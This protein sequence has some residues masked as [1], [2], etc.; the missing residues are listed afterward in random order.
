MIFLLIGIAIIALALAFYLGFRYHSW[1]SSSPKQ[2]EKNELPSAPTIEK[3]LEPTQ[4]IPLL[5]SD[6]PS[7][8]SPKKIFDLSS[9]LPNGFPTTQTLSIGEVL[10][11]DGLEVLFSD[12]M[13]DGRCPEEA[14][15]LVA[16]EAV[17]ELTVRTGAQNYKVYLTTIRGG[18]SD[19][20]V[21]WSYTEKNYPA[22]MLKQ[23]QT[24]QNIAKNTTYIQGSGYRSSRAV[25]AGYTFHLESLT[26]NRRLADRNVSV[27][28]Q[29]IA[30]ADYRAIIVVD[31]Q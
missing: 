18:K 26:P 19:Y 10:K 2:P 4:T 8:D 15:C 25:V 21:G 5:D 31:K 20:W 16:G 24:A 30:K 23:I 17:V 3:H 6:K 7:F 9:G 29:I 14:D 27:A 22:D 11:T 1:F 28:P 12:V 13:Y